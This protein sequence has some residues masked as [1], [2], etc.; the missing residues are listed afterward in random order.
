MKRCHVIFGV[1]MLYKGFLNYQFSERSNVVV[2]TNGDF[3]HAK[4]LEVPWN[5]A[6]LFFRASDRFLFGVAVS[7]QVDGLLSMIVR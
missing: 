5:V 4:A 7:S 2:V 1:W 3:H 6:F